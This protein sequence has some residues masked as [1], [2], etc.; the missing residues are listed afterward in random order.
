MDKF[1][2]LGVRSAY[3]PVSTIAETTHDGDE[4]SLVPVGS[5]RWKLAG[6]VKGVR[7]PS[8]TGQL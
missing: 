1:R 6:K 5:E 3:Y 2:K 8:A 7:T 4:G